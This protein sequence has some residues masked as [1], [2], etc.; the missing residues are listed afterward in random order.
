MVEPYNSTYQQFT[1]LLFDHTY[2]KIIIV[3]NLIFIQSSKQS[4]NPTPYTVL[5]NTLN[6]YMKL[7]TER[8]KGHVDSYGH[9]GWSDHNF[10]YWEFQLN[11]MSSTKEWVVLKT[12]SDDWCLK[13]PKEE[14]FFQD[15]NTVFPFPM[16]YLNS[17][18][19]AAGEGGA[20]SSCPGPG[21]F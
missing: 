10:S 5:I 9:C 8:G 1:F 15:T 13:N 18:Y 7:N 4:S 11:V 19:Y 12:L 3:I 2:N 21:F 6:W 17:S 16:C 14:G 20:V